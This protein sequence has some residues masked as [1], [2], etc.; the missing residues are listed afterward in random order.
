MSR[1]VEKIFDDTV[2]SD[3]LNDYIEKG[4]N[5][6]SITHDDKGNIWLSYNVPAAWEISPDGWYPYCSACGTE[7]SREH[8]AHGLPQYCPTCKSEMFNYKLFEKRKY[9]D[10]R[11]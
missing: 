3:K 4:I 7:P 9:E 11:K 5:H 8:T 1:Q 2:L 10:D 6:F